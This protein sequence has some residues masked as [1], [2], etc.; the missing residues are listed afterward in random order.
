MLA[1]WLSSPLGARPWEGASGVFFVYILIVAALLPALP[2]GG[3]LR[4]AALSSAG[5][6]LTLA[7]R[8]LE[9]HPVLH[10]WF[11]PPVLLLL[12]YWASGALFVAPMPR[13]EHTLMAIDRRFGIR[14]M[15]ERAPVVLVELLELAYAGVY[16]LI[17]IALALH[18]EWTP[19]P[20]AAAF[21]TVVLV[22]DYVCFATLPWIQARPPRAIEPGAPWQSRVRPFNR[23]LLHSAS[24]QMNTFPSGH[25][26]EAMAAALLV[27]GAPPLAVATMFL[28]ALAVSA[29]AVFGRY[30]YALDALLGWAVAGAVWLLV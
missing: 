7:S 23:W 21:W 28:A 22:T 18:L 30:H 24:I 4:A 14:K 11:I 5:L 26:A 12:A 6:A 1:T 27:T 2:R 25:A 13:V 15:A 17:P 10:A 3:R 8:L 9:T 16:P 19:S 20:S 29:G